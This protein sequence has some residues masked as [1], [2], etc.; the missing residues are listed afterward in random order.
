MYDNSMA[1]AMTWDPTAIFVGVKVIDDTHSNQ[2]SGWNG[3][4]LML[5]STD[6][7]RTEG[8]IKL[9]SAI[10]DEGNLVDVSTIQGNICTF[11]PSTGKHQ[12]LYDD[13][14]NVG[15]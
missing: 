13:K 1:F 12:I 4:S 15:F 5:L 11:N 6:A 3:D 2:G 10:D 14:A 8:H 9:N 7:A